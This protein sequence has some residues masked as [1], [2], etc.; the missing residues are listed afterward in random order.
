MSI[1]RGI[2]AG[3]IAIL[4]IVALSISGGRLA[5]AFDE[6]AYSMKNSGEV[7]IAQDG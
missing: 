3:A 2:I 7:I 6:V 4:A 1:E 5:Q